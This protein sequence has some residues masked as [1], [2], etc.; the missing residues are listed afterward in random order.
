VS[1]PVL[2]A[3]VTGL[4]ISIIVGQLD[5]LVGVEVEGESTVAKLLDLLSQL[6]SWQV[7]TLAIGVGAIATMLLVERFAERVPAAILV[8][9]VGMVLIAV[10]DP[11][12]VA[13]VGEVPRGLPSVGVPSLSLTDWLELLAGGV[14]LLF[15]G[16]SEGYAA[17]T[18][19]GAETGETIDPDQELFATGTANITAGLFGGM[20]VG[21]SLSKS[22]ASQANGARTQVANIVAGIVVVATLLFLGPLFDYLPE[23]VLAAIVIV[24]VLRS[25]D[26]RRVIAMWEVNRLDFFAAAITFTLVLV[27]ETLPAMIVG[28]L[29]SLVFVVRRAS[30]PDVLELRRNTDGLLVSTD[31]RGELETIDGVVVLRLEAPLIYANADRLVRAAITLVDRRPDARRLVLDAEMM[32]DLDTTGAETLE[33]LDDRLAGRNVEL[34]VARLH[35]RARSQIERSRLAQRFEHR[36][37]TSLRDALGTSHDR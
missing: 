11:V 21:G 1:K 12:T 20:A 24:A 9:A 16:F 7:V 30:F 4:A 31:D 35:H 23:P 15:V 19:V 33:S 6:S 3:F 14:A 25:A 37:H 36:M 2:H 10:F 26:P 28:V 27:W 32:S 34:H 8:V 18:A 17:S 13:V 29:L 22:A 5:G